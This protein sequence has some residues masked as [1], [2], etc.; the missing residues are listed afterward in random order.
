MLQTRVIPVLLLKGKGLVKTVK[1]NNP[2][3]IGDPFN[4]VKIF[5]DKEVDELLVFDI[6]ASK[7]NRGPD[8]NL[9]KGISSECF[10]PLGYG[11][12]IRDLND[13]KQLFS[14]G[15]EKVVLNSNVQNNLKLIEDASK[16]FGSQ[17]IVVCIDIIKKNI[18][19]K[20]CIYDH[21][22]SKSLK[23][24][25]FDYLKNIEKFGAGEVI[26]HSVDL[27]GT[28]KGYDL[29][30]IEVVSNVLSIPLVICGGAKD[31]KDFR[32][33]RDKGANAVAAGSLFVFHGPH[34]AV[35][36]SYPTQKEIKNLY[37]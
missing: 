25:F 33:A 21:I 30:L 24:N 19:G 3:Y 32:L 34:K 16:I 22:S 6:T 13:I 27:D 5:N 18:T 28:C 37:E 9:I 35:L 10:M 17:S 4:A 26:L 12:G 23:L 29:K 7:E 15:V 20:Y 11:G 36:L 2:K 8:F 1:F 31:L 14:L